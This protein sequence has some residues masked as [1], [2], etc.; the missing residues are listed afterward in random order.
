MTVEMLQ[1]LQ[2]LRSLPL[3]VQYGASAL[4]A[5]AFFGL[6]YLLGGLDL[7]PSQLPLFML[8]IPAVILAA[9]LFDRG[10]GYFAVLV[11]AGL[12]LYFMLDPRQPLDAFRLGDATSLAAF[13]VAGLFAV[14]IVQT[15]RRNLDLL[16][17]R[18]GRL[19]RS[20]AE[21][22][23]QVLGLEAGDAQKEL[24]LS[25]I[26]HRIKNQLQ[27][28]AG[29][30]LIGQRD[31]A[32][33][34]A[35]ELLGTAANRLKVLARVYDRL[36]LRRETTTVSA[37][38]FVE[39]MVNDLQPSLIGLRPIVLRAEAEEAEMSSGRAVTIGLMINE[40][41]TNAVRFAFAEDEPGNIFVYFR[42]A[43]DG[44]SLE[45]IDDGRGFRS[46]AR[47]GS[48]GQR[49]LRGLVAQLEGTIIWSGPPG[50]R[51]TVTFPAETG[52]SETE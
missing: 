18:S 17:E 45:V 21:L 35:A 49:M 48:V 50:T 51:V 6:R 31:I 39:E 44:F 23:A 36:Q 4:I 9:F 41:V 16:V 10:S 2:P 3:L 29:Y 14:A 34:R 24:L 43:E 40:L 25:D 7:E 22:E 52:F 15:L 46:E 28:V 38:G 5:L 27:V 11:S 47:S 19:A 1:R 37:R 42:R 13:I 20:C 32:D 8:F 33:E 12:G 26:N 30:M